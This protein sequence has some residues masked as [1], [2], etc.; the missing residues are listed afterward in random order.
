MIADRILLVFKHIS[1]Y[2]FFDCLIAFRLIDFTVGCHDCRPDSVGFGA[3]FT[4]W[5]PCLLA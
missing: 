2:G 4:V 1:L 5:F 3:Y